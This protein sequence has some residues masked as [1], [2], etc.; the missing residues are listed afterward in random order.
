MWHATET[1]CLKLRPELLFTKYGLSYF[2]QTKKKKK[3]ERERK[4]ACFRKTFFIT[5]LLATHADMELL[6]YFG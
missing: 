1:H 2:M 4:T 5:L 6:L 3:I